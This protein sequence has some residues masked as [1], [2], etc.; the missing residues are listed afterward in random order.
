MK[1]KWFSNIFQL[2]FLILTKI[3]PIISLQF[4]CLSAP[5]Q[6]DDIDYGT[7]LDRDGEKQ[8]YFDGFLPG[9]HKCGC[10]TEGTCSSPTE[11]CNSDSKE[12]IVQEDKG[13]NH[14]NKFI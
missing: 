14:I 6:L 3:L 8:N 9:I 10:A 4:K 2:D 1:L 13:F 11:T 12:P 5:L 7:W